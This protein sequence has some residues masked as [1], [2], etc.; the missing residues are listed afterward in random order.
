[1]IITPRNLAVDYLIPVHFFRNVCISMAC[2]GHA[3]GSGV[4]APHPPYQSKAQETRTLSDLKNN[5][6]L[7]WLQGFC[8]FF[9]GAM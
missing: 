4:I 5:I 8:I 7:Q 9:G 6:G 2:C 3:G 1:M